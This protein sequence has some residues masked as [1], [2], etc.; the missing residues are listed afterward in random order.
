[1][2]K[3]LGMYAPQFQLWQQRKPEEQKWLLARKQNVPL[4]VVEEFGLWYDGME[5]MENPIYIL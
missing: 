2:Y 5:D 4:E 1:M 3:L